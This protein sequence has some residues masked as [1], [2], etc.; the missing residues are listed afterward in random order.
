MEAQLVNINNAILNSVIIIYL[1]F[2]KG[3]NLQ[4]TFRV[5]A[6]IK[7]CKNER[8]ESTAVTKKDIYFS[9]GEIK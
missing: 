6:S 7:R 8:I 5:Y 9:K 2:N 4:L 1:K 3:Q